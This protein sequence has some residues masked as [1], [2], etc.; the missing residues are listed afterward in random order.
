MDEKVCATYI[1]ATAGCKPKSA[2][3][4]RHTKFQ[5]PE[6]DARQAKVRINSRKNEFELGAKRGNV[7]RRCRG[8]DFLPQQGVMLARKGAR[9]EEN[10]CGYTK[11]TTNMSDEEKGKMKDLKEMRLWGVEQATSRFRWGGNSNDPWAPRIRGLASVVDDTVQKGKLSDLLPKFV[12]YATA[13]AQLVAYLP[14]FP[15]EIL[16]L[17]FSCDWNN[18]TETNVFCVS[19]GW[20]N[21]SKAEFTL[22][23]A[24]QLHGDL[25]PLAF[26]EASAPVFLAAVG[27]EY[28]L[29]DGDATMLTRF[30]SNFA[31]DK[32]F[33]MQAA[34]ASPHI[35]SEE[36]EFG[37]AE[38]FSEDTD[39]IYARIDSE[40]RRLVWEKLGRKTWVRDWR[41]LGTHL[42][43]F[44]MTIEPNVFL[45]PLTDFPSGMAV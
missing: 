13:H 27:I 9:V 14:T 33:L 31:S 35:M 29:W 1:I 25:R 20:Y 22:S 44:V 5:Q 2:D 26:S 39:M 42:A 38:D 7:A 36:S 4:R 16:P 12:D 40:Q 30:G 3:V 10:W 18:W 24:F 43:K 28:V 34:A 23:H 6:E 21:L 19:H 32:D 11:K 37:V 15:Q 17:G 41:N 45:L 8:W